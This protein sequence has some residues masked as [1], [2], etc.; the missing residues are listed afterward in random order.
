M[1]RML[2]VI[3]AAA[4]AATP[5][6]A[7]PAQAA[8]DMFAKHCSAF[9]D[10]KDGAAAIEALSDLDPSIGVTEDGWAMT[11]AA[12][13]ETIEGID[14]HVAM[15]FNGT[16][17]DEGDSRTCSLHI[18]SKSMDDLPDV[19]AIAEA[20]ADSLIGEDL[21]R[22]GGEIHNF[23][24]QGV[25]YYYGY[26]SPEFPPLKILTVLVNGPQVSLTLLTYRS[27]E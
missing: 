15:G 10:S 21:Q 24:G 20:N 25:Q 17:D 9:A 4:L 27:A 26:E 12:V 5:A 19:A 1:T 22:R 2:P 14:G 3:A 11:G 6:D 16:S 7:D 8:W 18:I 13:S 23:I